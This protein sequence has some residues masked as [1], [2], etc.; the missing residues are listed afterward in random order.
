MLRWAINYKGEQQTEWLADTETEAIEAFA[1][2]NNFPH[3]EVKKITAEVV[4]R[5]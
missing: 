4:E 3:A 1:R 5:D 2:A